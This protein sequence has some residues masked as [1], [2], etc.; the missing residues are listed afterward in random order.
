MDIS[1]SIVLDQSN[2][3]AL[4]LHG[5]PS[6]FQTH[7]IVL[8]LP[9]GGQILDEINHFALPDHCHPQKT[10]E[11]ACLQIQTSKVTRHGLVLPPG[12]FAG[13]HACILTA[14]PTRHKS[15]L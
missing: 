12:K 1:Y 11:T 3:K 14:I 4:T 5:F 6:S 13:E 9:F 15:S 10:A 8:L 2:E 7:V